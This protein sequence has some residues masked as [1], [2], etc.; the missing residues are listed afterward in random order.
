[1]KTITEY[2]LKIKGVLDAGVG[3]WGLFVLVFLVAIS[4]FGLGRLS[5]LQ[6]ARP[7]VALAEAGQL[8]EPRALYIGGLTV[9]SKAGSVYYF[10][11]CSGADKITP[12]NQLWFASEE[13]ARE[14]GYSPAKTCKGLGG[15]Q[16][17]IQ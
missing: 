2:W 6:D 3:E 16:S 12:D 1:M 8:S 4:S 7:P 14:A 11:W 10:P 15:S 5:A 17:G 13:A 9:A